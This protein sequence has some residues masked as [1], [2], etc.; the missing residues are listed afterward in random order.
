MHTGDLASGGVCVEYHPLM[1][2]FWRFVKGEP[3]TAMRLTAA[4]MSRF[5]L[6]DD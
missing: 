4:L 5:L 1:D 6:E 2:V 3:S